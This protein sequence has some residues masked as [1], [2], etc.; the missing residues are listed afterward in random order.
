M[1]WNGFDRIKCYSVVT[2][3]KK[4]SDFY[5]Y[6]DRKMECSCWRSQWNEH[7]WL[8]SE[9]ADFIKSE[10]EFYQMESFSLN[11]TV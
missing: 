6:I 11:F 3:K 10:N 1:E 9:A 7:S 4:K 8:F 5:G 2:E